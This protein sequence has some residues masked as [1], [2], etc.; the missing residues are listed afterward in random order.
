LLARQSPRAAATRLALSLGWRWQ[1]LTQPQRS[2]LQPLR[3]RK[4]GQTESRADPA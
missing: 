2:R 3:G 1:R 4:P